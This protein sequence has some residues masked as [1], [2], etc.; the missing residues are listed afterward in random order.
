[1]AKK[2]A[3]AGPVQWSSE[4][5]W[6]VD[7]LFPAEPPPDNFRGLL[8]IPRYES[9][10]VILA[11]LMLGDL[12]ICIQ[13]A[14]DQYPDWNVWVPRKNG[15]VEVDVE[16]EARASGFASHTGMW[17]RHPGSCGRRRRWR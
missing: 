8:R 12:G 9:E 10:V 17:R 15:W 5:P 1:M 11:S 14:G 7:P 16:V 6:S 4:S 13:R 2:S 3:P